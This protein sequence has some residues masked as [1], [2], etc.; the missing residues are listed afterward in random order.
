MEAEEAHAH[1]LLSRKARSRLN[2]VHIG[3]ATFLGSGTYGIVCKSKDGL[4]EKS[5]PKNE[6]QDLVAFVREVAVMKA[7][8]AAGG[9]PHLLTCTAATVDPMK[10]LWMEDRGRTVYDLTEMKATDLTLAATH[11]LS[12]VLFLHSIRVAHRDVSLRNLLWHPAHGATLIDY[13][14]ARPMPCQPFQGST[15]YA[16]PVITTLDSRAPEIILESPAY[17]PFKADLWSAAACILQMFCRDVHAP[18]YDEPVVFAFWERLLGQRGA[19]GPALATWGSEGAAAAHRA[20]DKAVTK[21]YPLETALNWGEAL[22]TLT[23]SSHELAALVRALLVMDPAKRPSSSEVAAMP[24]VAM[25]KASHPAFAWM[26]RPLPSLNRV[27]GQATLASGTTLS[28]RPTHERGQGRRLA[29]RIARAHRAPAVAFSAMA[30]L[31]TVEGWPATHA[32]CEDLA[33]AAV[34]AASYLHESNP[35][36]STPR[37][38]AVTLRLIGLRGCNMAPCVYTPY[39]AMTTSPFFGDM[40]GECTAGKPCLRCAVLRHMSLAAI[41]CSP[42]PHPDVVFLWA[43]RQACVGLDTEGVA[44]AEAAVLAGL[45]PEEASCLEFC[46]GRIDDA[47]GVAPWHTMKDLPAYRGSPRCPHSLLVLT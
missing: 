6:P 34:S 18:H 17:D 15:N 37:V 44:G 21:R 45:L 14:M 33:R 27:W 38:A 25:R 2:D 41:A 39:A 42:M 30:V 13:G 8:E 7:V 10:R 1:K 12:S 11:L 20:F 4:V 46:M 24:F 36:V 35:W 3:D 31:D 40:G 43:L 23:A 22:R 47:V 32:D 16:S 28:L 29:F 9:H 19:T 26:H 5:L